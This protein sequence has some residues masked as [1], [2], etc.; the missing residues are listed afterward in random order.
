MRFHTL[1]PSTA[2]NLLIADS[3]TS[4]LSFP[5]FNILTIPGVKTWHVIDFLPTTGQFKVVVLF[6]GA[7]CLFDKNGNSVSSPIDV[8]EELSKLADRLVALADK[9]VII[10]LTPRFSQ[11][12][13]TAAVN[14]ILSDKAKS[15]K[16][17]FRGIAHKISINLLREDQIHL[18]DLGLSQIRSILKNKILYSKFS[19]TIDKAGH[20]PTVTCRERC[21]CGLYRP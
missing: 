16:W 14:R 9:V 17:I 21:N 3:Q 13:R 1:K 5:N 10:G 15:R 6:I 11:P 19:T 2:T 12:E 20:L 7:N 18:S 4:L 8:A